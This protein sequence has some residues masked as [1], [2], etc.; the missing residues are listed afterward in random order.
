MQL[1]D[2]LAL[3]DDQYLDE[4]VVAAALKRSVNTLRRW[5]C[6]RKGPARTSIGNTISYRVGAIRAW[7]RAQE[8]NFQDERQGVRRRRRA[9]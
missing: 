2:V 9:A 8:R 1:N 5:A 3:S 4:A 6:K 7:L